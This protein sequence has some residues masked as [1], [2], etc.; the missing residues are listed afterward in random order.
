MM[1]AEEGTGTD[2]DAVGEDAVRE[3]TSPVEGAPGAQVIIISGPSGVGK[4]TIIEAMQR[5]APDRTDRVYVIT[6]TT[7]DR[8]DYEV[9]GVHYLFRTEEDFARLRRSNGLLEYAEVHG[10]WYGTPRDQVVD[11]VT[12]GKDAIL[13]IDVQGARAVRQVIPD[14]LLVFVVPPSVA[15]LQARLIAR[16]TES[17]EAFA[18]RMKNAEFELARQDEYDHVVTNRTG[19]VEETADEIEAI[20]AAE[21][22]R[23]PDRRLRV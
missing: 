16:K 23:H 10:N 22:A 8:R 15:E 13:K 5:R 11:A 9:D 20:I 19:R 21:H 17:P 7:R 12:A 18:K 2:P 4:D 1:G 6:C 14:A 3:V